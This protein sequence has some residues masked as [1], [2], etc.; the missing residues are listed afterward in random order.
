M[1]LS[2]TLLLTATLFGCSHQTELSRPQQ[3]NHNAS[4]ANEHWQANQN[5]LRALANYRFA[6]LRTSG[7]ETRYSNISTDEIHYFQQRFTDQITR[8]LSGLVSFNPATNQPTAQLNVE[9]TFAERHPPPKSLS[10]LLPFLSSKETEDNEDQQ[11]TAAILITVTDRDSNSHIFSHSDQQTSSRY[12]PSTDSRSYPDID[13]LISRWSA[14]F[15]DNM[16]K[17]SHYYR[18]R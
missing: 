18:Q 12:A 4:A 1:R 16:A 10:D 14:E 5:D 7:P 11:L 15:G 13:E 17:L 9:I 3:P 2:A 8:Q 6:K